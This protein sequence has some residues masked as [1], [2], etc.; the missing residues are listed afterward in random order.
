M[1]SRILLMLSKV[2]RAQL[3]SMPSWL[4]NG[5]CT[6][7]TAAMQIR[8]KGYKGVVHIDTPDG[9]YMAAAA[10]AAGMDLATV[11][12]CDLLLRK[13]MRKV[14]GV[15]N[16]TLGLVAV[17]LPYKVGFLNQQFVLLLSALGEP[18]DV[19]LQQQ[20]EYF[21]ELDGLCSDAS[22]AT[23]YL[24]MDEKVSAGGLSAVQAA[25]G[26]RQQGCRTSATNSFGCCS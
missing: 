15:S 23:R 4:L 21:R 17:S 12:D 8:Y 19:L 16:A 11:A 26:W 3:C 18:D 14:G 7:V 6:L 2:L 20:A 5:C 13:S 24:L 10:T 22:V 1:P 9:A 25:P